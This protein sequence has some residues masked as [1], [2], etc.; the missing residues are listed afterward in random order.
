MKRNEKIGIGILLLILITMIGLLIITKR[1]ANQDSGNIVRPAPRESL[2]NNEELNE[3]YSQEKAI[4]KGYV[5]ITHNKIYN[6]DKLDK[7]MKN[8]EINSKN[9]I[10][11]SVKIVQYTTEGDP[12]ITE[13]SYKIKDETYEIGGETK[14]KT[15]Y[16]LK[17]DNTRDKWSA[18]KDRKIIINDDI[19]GDFYGII[20]EKEGNT[21]NIKLALYAII[22][23]VD[24]NAKV[25]EEIFV[26]SYPSN[27]EQAQNTYF[28]GKVIESHSN[29]IILEPNE[30][31]DIRKSADK[32]VVKL[33]ENNDA[34]Y[35]IGT[36]VKVTYKGYVMET[37]PAQVDVVSIEVKSAEQFELRFYDKSNQ[38]DNKIDKV[39]DKSET[40][41]YDY[42]VYNCE[43]SVNIL[44]EGKEMSLRDALLENKIT[45]DEILAK[46][47]KDLTDKKIKGDMYRDGG[48]MEYHYDNYTII[49]CHT[50]N[51]NRDMYIGNPE[52]TINDLEIYK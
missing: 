32:I 40:N 42:N 50:L 39:L 49:K 45:L 22:D 20:E 35:Q 6:K 16:I 43:G 5:V 26:C 31:E 18:E 14:N 4:E 2:T 29:S 8:T 11:D 12:I 19:P 34:L 7:F 3:N 23:Y 41:K 10:E 15:T 24:E 52:L 51:G 25:Y 47:N 48:S 46:A 33:G 36:N 37:Y 27:I 9:R 1:I 13:L 44:I 21:T 30:G 17:T 38:T 28:Y